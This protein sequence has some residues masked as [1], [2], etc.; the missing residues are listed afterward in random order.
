[1]IDVGC[2]RQELLKGDKQ[3]SERTSGQLKPRAKCLHSNRLRIGSI[4]WFR[5]KR[6]GYTTIGHGHSVSL[7]IGR[8]NIGVSC[9]LVPCLKGQKQHDRCELV[10]DVTNHH[11]DWKR[12]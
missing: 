5:E 8:A 3:Y 11:I 1:M 10:P 2:K 7:C 4:T 12:G 9:P 6:G